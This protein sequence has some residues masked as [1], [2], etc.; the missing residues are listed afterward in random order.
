MNRTNL[1][2]AHR[3]A[4]K[5]R[6]T[7]L[8][9]WG[10]ACAAYALAL[11]ATYGTC[12]ALMGASGTD[13]TDELTAAS[14][15]IPQ[16]KATTDSLQRQLAGAQL[17]L[18][19]DRSIGNQ[20]DWSILLASLAADLGEEIVLRQCRLSPAE[21]PQTAQPAAAGAAP[22]GD[23]APTAAQRRFT[24]DISGYGR[25]QTAVSAFVIRLE[26]RR[27]FDH[28]KLVRTSREPLLSAT[29]ISFQLE[30]SLGNTGARA[31]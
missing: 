16:V 25:S 3:A 12:R 19:A 21:A 11:L 6:G 20:P 2:P 15:K 4:A 22:G 29:A 26:E 28:V 5:R 10:L 24:L 30:C 9:H 8:R 31:K 27:L 18:A 23:P 14:Q 17:E 7:R 13:L 1:M